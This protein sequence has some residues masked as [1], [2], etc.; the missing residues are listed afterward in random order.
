VSAAIVRQTLSDQV[1]DAVV[2]LIYDEGLRPG[3]EMPTEGALAERLGVSR[4]VVREAMRTLRA[5]QIVDGGQGRPARVRVPDATLLGRL[6][7]YSLRQEAITFP[8]L[9]ATR[10]TIETELAA[11][12]AANGLDPTDAEEARETLARMAAATGED[13][14]DAFIAADLAFHSLIADASGNTLLALVLRGLERLLLAAREATH[15]RR[16]AEG[17]SVQEVLD[18]HRRILEAILARDPDAARAAMLEHLRQ[19]AMDAPR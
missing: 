4:I 10:R 7:D 13:E 8:Q 11:A 6:F 14:L 2:A 9:L 17:R 15:R 18:A 19:T 3:D 12:A 5:H 1:A 16:L